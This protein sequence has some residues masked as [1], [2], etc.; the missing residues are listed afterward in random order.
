[1][2]DEF[3]EIETDT[4]PESESSESINESERESINESIKESAKESIKESVEE[5]VRESVKDKVKDD[6]VN[7]LTCGASISFSALFTVFALS[8][9][10][11]TKKRKR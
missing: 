10:A 4:L 3:T 2:I 8:A 11:T 6:I 1:M 9:L 7:T 5:S